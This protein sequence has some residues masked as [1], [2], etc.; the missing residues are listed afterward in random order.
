MILS[1]H[2]Q[3]ERMARLA[4]VAGVLDIRG[5]F[6][7]SERKGKPGQFQPRITFRPWRVSDARASEALREIL[8]GHVSTMG[9]TV[10][11]RNV[12]TLSGAEACLTADELLAPYLRLRARRA[13]FHAELCRMIVDYK[14]SSWS[15]RSLPP[16]EIKTRQLLARSMMLS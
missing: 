1:I 10:S 6:T 8:G 5:N 15:D 7:A 3:V 14:R 12:W 11:E 2:E 4:W 13:Q 16:E 9:M